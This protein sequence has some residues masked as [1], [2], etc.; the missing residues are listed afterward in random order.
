MSVSGGETFDLETLPGGAPSEYRVVATEERTAGQAT[1][2]GCGEEELEQPPELPDLPF[3][4]A[5]LTAEK[6]TVPS[7]GSARDRHRHRASESEVRQQHRRRR[8]LRGRSDRGHER[9]VLAGPRC[10]TD[11][12]HDV[13]ED[14]QRS[15]QREQRQQRLVQRAQRIRQLLEEQLRLHFRERSP[16]CSPGSPRRRIPHRVSRGSADCVRQ[17][18]ATAFRRSSRSTAW[19]RDAKLVG[20]EI[21]HNFG[22][23]HTHC[24]SPAIDHCVSYGGLVLLGRHFVPRRAREL[25]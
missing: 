6:S 21:G 17:P 19:L 3:A 4:A 22:S 11:P 25:S 7:G 20:H 10:H 12:G 5:A 18:T 15:L 2:W 8:R 1:H 16:R 9:H 23:P 24:Y 13:S 14:R